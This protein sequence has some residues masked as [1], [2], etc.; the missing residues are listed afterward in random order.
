MWEEDEEGFSEFESLESQFTPPTPVV[1]A[2]SQQLEQIIEDSA[3]DLSEG[4]SNIVYNVRLR[5]EMA[6]LYEMLINHNVFEGVDASDQAISIVQGEMKNYIVERLEVLLGIKQATVERKI[7]RVV[8]QVES[9]F[10]D[11]EIEFLKQMAYKGTLGKSIGANT[12][13]PLVAKKEAKPKL[14]KIASKPAPT[15][16]SPPLKSSKPKAKPKANNPIR[17]KKVKKISTSGKTIE[18]IAKEEI[19]RERGMADFSTLSS[20]DKS[21]RIREVNQRHSRKESS[22]AKPMMTTQQLESELT[23]RDQLGSTS[24]TQQFNSMLKDIVMNK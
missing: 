23:M 22:T 9:P 16:K 17:K 21:K 3:F 10:N 24:K 18:Q 1:E 13:K 11:I 14:K 6:K 12:P 15:K 5:L 2:E 20:E 8:E 7:E 4:E 19:D